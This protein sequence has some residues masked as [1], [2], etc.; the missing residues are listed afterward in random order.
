[1]NKSN[2]FY[3]LARIIR[4]QETATLSAKTVCG[5]LASISVS[6]GEVQAIRYSNQVGA[7]AL[8]AFQSF[9]VASFTCKNISSSLFYKATEYPITTQEVLVALSDRMALPQDLLPAESLISD[10]LMQEQRSEA[11]SSQAHQLSYRG[12]PVTPAMAANDATPEQ[13]KSYKIQYR[14][15]Q[16]NPFLR[17]KKK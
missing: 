14:G 5:H 3:D 7:A 6:A 11:S 10:S 15:S 8:A 2:F 17:R 16:G 9:E 12:Q 13:P 4:H 1:M